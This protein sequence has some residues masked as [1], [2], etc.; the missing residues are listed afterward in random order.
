MLTEGSSCCDLISSGSET[1]ALKLTELLTGE[2]QIDSKKWLLLIVWPTA[3]RWVV[4]GVGEPLKLEHSRVIGWNAMCTLILQELPND[5]LTI[6]Q[7]KIHLFLGDYAQFSISDTNTHDLL[8]VHGSMS[9]ILTVK[10]PNKVQ[11][12]IRILLFLILNEAQH[13]SGDKPPI[14]RSLKP[15]KQPLV[16]HKWKVVGRAV[17]GR[18]QV[19]YAT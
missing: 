8:D 6:W 1:T 12:C 16:L 15:H 14:I 9:T 5:V 17:V 3:W 11:Q 13:V 19:A 4:R 2:K 18:C 10:T 7:Y